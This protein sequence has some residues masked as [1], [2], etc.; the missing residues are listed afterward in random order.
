MNLKF[1][2]AEPSFS[3]PGWV[4]EARYPNMADENILNIEK[5]IDEIIQYKERAYVS[6]P[7][8]DR[9]MGNAV[10]YILY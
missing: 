2:M 7:K 8:T 6:R 3:N 1:Y 10:I 9:Y 5:I 4:H